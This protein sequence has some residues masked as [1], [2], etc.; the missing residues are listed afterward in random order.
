MVT[1]VLDRR[2]RFPHTE[3][4]SWRC[5][6]EDRLFS[7]HDV[8]GPVRVRLLGGSVLAEMTARRRGGSKSEEK[9]AGE[10]RRRRCGGRQ[11]HGAAARFG[12]AP[13]SRPARR[14]AG[15]LRCPSAASRRRHRRRRQATFLLATAPGARSRRPH[16]RGWA[17]R[18]GI[19]RA[20]PGPPADRLTAGARCHPPPDARCAAVGQTIFAR[21]C[22]QDLLGFAHLLP[23]VW[24][25]PRLVRSRIVA[26]G[27]SAGGL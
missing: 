1:G 6:Q 11:W 5:G 20:E 2:T 9:L 12:C 8:L 16:L 3:R 19:A 4:V 25:P 26:A 14:G 21:V 24:P 10:G 22:A 15:A 23:R 18:T 17:M 27:P 7:V 13:V